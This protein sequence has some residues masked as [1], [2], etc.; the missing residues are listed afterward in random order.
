MME[1]R[2]MNMK[3]NLYTILAAAAVFAGCTETTGVDPE[4]YVYPLFFDLSGEKVVFDIDGG[5]AALAV[6]TNAETLDYTASGDWFTVENDGNGFLKIS[7]PA[8]YSPETRTGTVELTAVLGEETMAATVSVTQRS[9][10]SVNLSAAG[11]SNCYLVRTGTSYTFDATVKGNGG[12]DGRS[13]YI[14]TCGVDITGISYADLLWEARTDGDKTM[15]REIIDGVPVYNDGYVSFTTG[16]MEGNALI[17]VKDYDGKVLWSWH[18]WVCDDEITVHDH[19]N[20][21]DEVSGQIMDRNLGALNNTPMDVNNK[22]MFYQW[23]RKDPFMPSSSPY[24]GDADSGNV[25]EY[26]RA[27]LEVGDGTGEWL[28]SEDYRAQLLSEP[29]ANIPYSVQNPM[30][31]LRPYGGTG[32]YH[33]YVASMSDEALVSSLWSAEEKTIFDPCPQGYRVPGHNFYGIASELD[34]NS[35]TTGGSGDTD[36]NGE[37]YPWETAKD[38]GR[39]WRKTGDYYP[40]AGNLYPVGESTHNYCS[41]MGYYWVA[42]EMENGSNARS[43]SFRFNENIATYYAS[44]EDFCYQIRCVKE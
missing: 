39:I 22:G 17:A 35:Y 42:H 4:E 1:G 25:P 3:K 23:G 36:E 43:F 38:C 7:A 10:N 21:R 44:G 5:M 33:W 41:G 15:S 40:M 29:P 28:I 6:A 8:N 13:H 19:I 32:G 9:D 20:P 26:N 12:S 27:S 16:R 18:I 11:T 37:L 2:E 24:H 14:E 34:V 30:M 31:F